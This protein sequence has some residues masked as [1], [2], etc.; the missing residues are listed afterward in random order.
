M[1]WKYAFGY[2]LQ[3]LKY[4]GQRTIV[5]VLSVAF[6]V[7][8][9]VA[10]SV[11]SAVISEV[12]LVDPRIKMGGDARLWRQE[13][14]I[15]PEHLA[16][17]QALAA[18]GQI[19]GYAMVERAGALV[20]RTPDSGRVTFLRGGLGIDPQTYPL[21]GQIKIGLPRHAT[22]A[23][24]LAEPWSVVITRDIARERGLS[25]GDTLLLSNR[26]GGR[27]YEMK[28]SAIATNTPGYVGEVVY[29]SLQTTRL[30][31]GHALPATEI[32]VLWNGE[33]GAVQADLAD[34]GWR[35][36]YFFVTR[37]VIDKGWLQDAFIDNDV[38]GSD[39]CPVGITLQIN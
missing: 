4:G 2:A 21:L 26:L 3:G 33:P 20:M 16:Q 28:V 10:M 6:G 34:A 36:D 25:V 31:T 39:H 27:P 11:L 29:Y 18:E 23:E 35:I 24:A 17:I 14:P 7:M 19:Q 15:A 1:R 30:I 9:V 13:T 12:L 8:S 37:D 5:A 38:F 32:L 22:L